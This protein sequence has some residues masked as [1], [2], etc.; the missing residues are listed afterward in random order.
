MKFP[1]VEIITQ[2]AHYKVLMDHASYL[3]NALSES[4]SENTRLSE[5]LQSFL[6]TRQQW[7]EAVE[8]RRNDVSLMYIG[9]IL[10]SPRQAK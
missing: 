9:S 6:D 1:P 7:K 3:T 5:E 10:F 4:Q 2:S 8:V